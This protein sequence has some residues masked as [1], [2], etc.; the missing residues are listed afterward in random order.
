MAARFDKIYNDIVDLLSAKLSP[1]LKYHCVDHTIYVVEMAEYI[2]KKEKVS[3]SNLYLLKIAALFHDI[4]FIEGPEEHE[5]TSCKIAKREL[6]KYGLSKEQIMVICGMIMATRIPQSPQ[7]KLE[8][9]IA[10]AD[11]EYLSTSKYEEVSEQLY[12]ELRHFNKKFNR[13][14]WFKVQV[15]FISNHRYHTNYCKRYKE[16]RKMRNLEKM[17]NEYNS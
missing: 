8:N 6:K 7:N 2:A 11:L 3:S 4:G 16:F 10:D 13:Q 12:E 15:D 1:F 14:K 17:I 9:I 5:K